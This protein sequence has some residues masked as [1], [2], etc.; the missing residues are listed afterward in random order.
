[1]FST[2]QWLAKNVNVESIPSNLT[3][4]GMPITTHDIPNA[5]AAFFNEKITAHVNHVTVS[6][7]V[8]KG[9]NKIIVQ[10]RNFMLMSDIS[11]LFI[12]HWPM[13]LIMERT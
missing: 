10:N 3:L 11:L 5:F 9:K 13:I 8:Y 2:S 6:R 4:G 7:N 1:M 12:L